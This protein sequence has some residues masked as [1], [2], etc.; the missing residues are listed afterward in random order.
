MSPP[1]LSFACALA[2]AGCTFVPS[3]DATRSD[4]APGGDGGAPIDAAPGVDGPHEDIHHVA[5]A[6]EY[7]GDADVEITAAVTLDTTALAVTA[8]SAP[9]FTLMQAPAEGGGPELAIAHVRDL[10]V[11]GTLRVVG[12]RPLVIIARSISIDGELDGGGHGGTPGPGGGGPGGGA[13]HGQD[14]QRHGT[15]NDTGGGGGGFATAGAIGGNDG[16]GDGGGGAAYGDAMLAALEGGSGGGSADGDCSEGPPGAGGGAVQLYATVSIAITGKINAGGGGGGGGHGCAFQYTAGR[17]GGSGGAIYLQAPQV[18]L[19][20]TIAANG[21]GG[22]G[23]ADFNDGGGGQDG[24]V[25]TAPAS[26]GDAGGGNYGARG[27]D[28]GTDVAPT[29]GGDNDGDGNGG[30]GGGAAGR[31]VI[32][33]RNAQLLGTSSPTAAVAPY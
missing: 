15:F 7:L 16:N 3:G 10:R 21:G 30:G 20:G 23:G 9:G 17:G 14:G 32:R 33:T 19:D 28:G 26:G 13:G 2:L 18:V 22:G 6:Q 4:D 27:G 8:G 25:G 29:A 11:T 24:A 12:A 31:I 1:T 5:L